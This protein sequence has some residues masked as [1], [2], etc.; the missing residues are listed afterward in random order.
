MGVLSLVAGGY[1]VRL[2]NQGHLKLENLPREVERLSLANAL[3]DFRRTRQENA[4][5]GRPEGRTAETE[6]GACG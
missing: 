4:R 6:A 5:A 1:G 3:D 2:F